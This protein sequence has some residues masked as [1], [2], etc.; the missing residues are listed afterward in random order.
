MLENWIAP[1]RSGDSEKAWDL[2]LERYRRLI[3]GA[4]RR[5]AKGGDADEVMDVFAH[6]CERLR[7]RDFARLRDAAARFD[8]DRPISTWIVAVVRNLTI[9]WL[10]HCHGRSRLSAFAEKLPALQQRIY[11]CVFVEQRSHRETYELL[12]TRRELSLSFGD[13][14]KEVSATYRSVRSGNWGSL[15]MELAPSTTNSLVDPF[16]EDSVIAGDRQARLAEAMSALS[17][18]DKLALQLYI[19][20]GVSADE[21]ARLLSWTGAKAVYNRVYRALSALRRRFERAGIKEGDL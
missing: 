19:V 17:D 11:Q 7:E 3:F 14:L 20:E 13:F 8:P 12:S 4:I 5:Y 6:V 15:I 9:D 21:V 16:E 1:L 10:R 2:F 18:D